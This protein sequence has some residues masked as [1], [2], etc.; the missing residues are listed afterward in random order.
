M[1]GDNGTRTRESGAGV[2]VLPR[3]SGRLPPTSVGTS[4]GLV[5]VCD[6]GSFARRRHG[7]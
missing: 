7:A 6:P 4:E 2:G 3:N 1:G 5:E